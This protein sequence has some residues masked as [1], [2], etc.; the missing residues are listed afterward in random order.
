MRYEI[1]I[2]G[3]GGQGVI[4]AGIILAEAAILDKFYV[5]HSQDYGPEARGGNSASEVILSDAEID[6]PKAMGLDLLLALNPKACHENLPAM[7][8]DGLVIV[9]STQVANIPWRKTVEVPISGRTQQKLRNVRVANILALGTLVPFCGL[10]SSRS[11]ERAIKKRM[12]ADSAQLNLSAF[13]E[14]LKLARHVKEG[15]KFSEIE[16]ATE[17]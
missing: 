14:G 13:R 10:I 2:A 12:P 5:I 11:L 8:P 17:V 1:R 16:G 7:K 3:S 4:L 15:I 6:Y 9:D